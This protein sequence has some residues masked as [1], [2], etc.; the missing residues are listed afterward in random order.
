MY[1]KDLSKRL[2]SSLS[3]IAVLFFIIYYAKTPVLQIVITFLILGL[4]AVALL[5]FAR[6]AKRKKI[7]IERLFFIGGGVLFTFSFLFLPFF[8][9]LPFM[10]FFLF[11]LVLF[12]FN[13]QKIQD[14]F[15]SIGTNILGLLYIALP[16]GL[17]F[18]LLYSLN[19]DGRVWIFYLLAV[20]KASDIGG[21][22]G[23]SLF[24]RR[25]IAPFLSPKKTVAG[26]FSGAFLSVFVSYVFYQLGQTGFFENFSLTF[27]QALGLGL[28]LAF[29]AQVGDLAESLL[30]RDAEVK[31]SG[32]L[33]GLGGVLD[34][35]DS[36]L[37]NLPLMFFYLE[38]LK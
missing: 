29:G 6:L 1:F 31:D 19:E 33:P 24:G 21:Y 26:A 9:F 12:L 25:K 34:M 37:F 23:G 27:L 38:V 10:V 14:A 8:R 5:E 7:K 18:P 36:L 17:V 20:S 22:F 28:V 11:F 3:I 2:L 16:L 35:L 15:F 30:K 13:F 32:H 4:S